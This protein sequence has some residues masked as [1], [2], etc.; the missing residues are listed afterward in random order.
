M[1]NIALFGP[2]GAGKGTQSKSLLEKYNLTY[3]ATGDIL[4]QEI[5]EGTPLGMEAKDIID[6]GGL[7]SDEII[8]QILEN[9]IMANPD[10]NGILFDGFPR[11]VVQAYI[12]E[13]L[14]LKMNTSLMCM[15]SLEVPEKE[16]V[17]R[18][19]ERGKVSG[20][21]D[22][23]EDV[24][25]FRLQEY[26]NKTLPVAAFYSEKKKFF[27]I[28]GVGKVEDVLKRLTKAVEKNLENV[29]LNIVLFGPPGGGKGTQAKKLAEKYNL[30]YISTGELLR[31]EIE[32]DTEM[33]KIARVY[34]DKGDIVPDEIA[35]RL[36]EGK[37]K[38]N[39][40]A[41]GFIFKG[42]PSSIVQAYILDGL[43]QRLGTAVTGM[44]EI[45]STT[46]QSIKRLS[47][48][49]KTESARVY[50]LDPE[51]IIHRLEVYENKSPKVAEYFQKQNKFSSVSGEGNA[52]DVFQRLSLSVDCLMKNI[53]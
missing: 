2:P 52:E 10:S 51:I 4:R 27:P 33:G 41:K 3:I 16:L 30:V 25:K 23:K 22:D 26:K 34:M 20:R 50:D 24:I 17:H 32:N 37:I 7:A 29:W 48:R 42:Y 43:L 13:G 49:A 6:K 45:T 9:R 14:L 40:T 15:L 39:P 12:L 19:L 46:L 21:A 11:T 5:L 38:M 53:R 1:L 35:I 47:A 44:L 8:V 18:M 28:N 31:K 36:I